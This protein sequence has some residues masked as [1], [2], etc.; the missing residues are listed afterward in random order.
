LPKELQRNDKAKEKERYRKS[1]GKEIKG[2]K[3]RQKLMQCK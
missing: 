2:E 1:K 3:G